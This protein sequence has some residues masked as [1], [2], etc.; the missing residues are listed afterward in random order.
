[1]KQKD[2]NALKLSNTPSI[3]LSLNEYCLRKLWYSSTP[4]VGYFT[5][6]AEDMKITKQITYTISGHQVNVQNGEQAVAFEIKENDNL[7]YFGTSFQF[8]IPNT[9]S[10]DR[11]KLYAV[12][13]DGVRIEMTRK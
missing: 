1:M 6:F 2:L 4:D 5:Q 12:Q 13:A 11:V 9:I 10:P 3:A 7:K 8:E